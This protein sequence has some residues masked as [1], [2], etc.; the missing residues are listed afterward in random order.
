LQIRTA[1]STADSPPGGFPDPPSRFFVVID[2]F[3]QQQQQQ[4]RYPGLIRHGSD[5]SDRNRLTGLIRDP[6]RSFRV[7]G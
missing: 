4:Q 7:C 1:G 2:R 3:Q 5:S 6:D